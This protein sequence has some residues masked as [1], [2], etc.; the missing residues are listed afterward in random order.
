MPIL[1]LP[2]RVERIG[3]ERP[4]LVFRLER[5]SK[6]LAVRAPHDAEPVSVLLDRC[7]RASPGDTVSPP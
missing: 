3:C 5:A 7:H 1:L 4:R 6:P 2:L